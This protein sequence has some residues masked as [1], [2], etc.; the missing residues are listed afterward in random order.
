MRT[1]KIRSDSWIFSIE[2]LSRRVGSVISPRIFVSVTTKDARWRHGSMLP[3]FPAFLDFHVDEIHLE[4]ASREFAE[5]ELC[6]RDC[7][8]EDCVGWDY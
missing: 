2:R 4:M 8:D 7:E 6:A 3:M 5:L 1:A